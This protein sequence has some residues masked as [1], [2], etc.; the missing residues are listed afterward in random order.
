MGGHSLCQPEYAYQGLMGV[1]YG[2]KIHLFY[3]SYH[4]EYDP[5]ADTYTRKADVPNPRSWATCA[6]VGSNIYLIGGWN[7]SGGGGTNTMQVLNPDTDTWDLTRM[8]MPVSRYGATRENPVIDGK[9]YVTHGWNF[10]GYFF[11]C[12]YV[13]DPVANTWELK[14]SANHARDGVA[15]GVINNKLYVVGGRNSDIVFGPPSAGLNYHEVYDPALDT[16]TTQ[17][18]PS[19]W[20]T[21]G[22]NY[23]Y[24]DATAC[25]SRQLLR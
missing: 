6:V 4:Y 8:P 25:I 21:S 15:C 24:S 14:G 22:S 3:G 1:V 2:D 9:I 23:A 5:V 17:A 13:Y 16:W 12:N 18:N 7:L 20:T 19:G 10:E 11:T